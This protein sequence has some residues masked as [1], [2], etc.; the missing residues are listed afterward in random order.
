MTKDELKKEAEEWRK[1]YKPMGITCIERDGVV[2]ETQ[3]KA[4]R[5]IENPNPFRIKDGWYELYLRDLD[6][7]YIA[8]ATE[9]GVQ[10]HDLRK[11]PN[12][13]PEYETEVI[14]ITE[15]DGSLYRSFEYYEVESSED[16]FD[17][18]STCQKI[19]AWCEIPQFK[20]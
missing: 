8:G 11:D 9:N 16:N 2:I 14:A 6:N 15:S 3:S 19:I 20:E 17:G 1:D 7:A 13:L 18:W 4:T 12:D 5:R 10:W